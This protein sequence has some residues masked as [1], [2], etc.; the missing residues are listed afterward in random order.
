VYLFGR[1]ESVVSD[2]SLRLKC[3]PATRGDAI[4]PKVPDTGFAILK[5]VNGLSGSLGSVWS[6]VDGEGFRFEVWGSKG[7]LVTTAPLFPQAFDTQ[8]FV[9]EAGLLG[10]RTQQRV[11]IPERLKTVP[12]SGVH[13]D[14]TSIA[15]FPMAAVF[16]S[17]CNDIAGRGR[18]APDFRQA[19]HVQEVIEAAVLSSDQGRWI[20]IADLP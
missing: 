10:Q 12:G 6:M 13:A 3:W 16:R 20:R 19:L 14:Q 11:E 9:S 5:F 2:Q 1:I 7:R 4:T 8:L 15:R 18:P 17:I